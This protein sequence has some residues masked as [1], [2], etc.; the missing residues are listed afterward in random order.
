MDPWS[1]AILLARLLGDANEDGMVDGLDYVAW[2]NSYDQTGGWG[3]ADFDYSTV[4]DG[5]DYVIWS[6]HYGNAMT[7]GLALVPEP[8]GLAMLGLG[9]LALLRRRQKS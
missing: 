5:L 1:G 3:E 7:P 4:V 9:A 2:S 8:A 6:N